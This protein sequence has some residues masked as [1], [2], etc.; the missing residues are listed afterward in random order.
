VRLPALQ[1]A[2]PAAALI[3][4]QRQPIKQRVLHQGP[5]LLAGQSALR[6]VA[7]PASRGAVRTASAG[8]RAA[9]V[10]RGLG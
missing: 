10:G 8:R 1:P 7:A 3:L 2:G 6:V 4:S 5:D 9:S